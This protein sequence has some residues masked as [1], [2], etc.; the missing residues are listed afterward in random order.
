MFPLPI[1]I[2]FELAAFIAGLFCWRSLV[3]TRL[4]WLIPFLGII[5]L[6]ELTGRYFPYVLKQ[7]NAWL[8]NLSVPFEY[9][10]YTFIFLLH[11]N[12]KINQFIA[13]GFL[14]LFS[15]YVVISLMFITGMYTFNVIFL[16]IG[17]LAMIILSILYLLEL[18]FS[19]E[20][21]AIW[22][23]PMFW[24]TIGIF[25]FNAGEFSYNLLSKYFFD[26]DFDATLKIFRSIN[27]RLILV[28]YSCFIIAFLCQKISGTYKKD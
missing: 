2:Y 24:I 27:N 26:N 6:V 18:Y 15:L 23:H 21:L 12:K 7:P 20:I 13:K 4:Q 14:L 17:S 16:N 19:D 10:F 8:Y 1:H 11:Y 25:L 5:V 22:V 3:K 9:L 28:L